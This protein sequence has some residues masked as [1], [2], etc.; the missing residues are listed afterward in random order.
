[1][2]IGY[3]C[4]KP[5][6]FH[7]CPQ[8]TQVITSNRQFINQCCGILPVYCMSM[9]Q[10]S[11]KCIWWT[12]VYVVCLTHGAWA[13][14]TLRK[15]RGLRSVEI[16]VVVLFCFTECGHLKSNRWWSTWRQR[17]EKIWN[18]N[19]PLKVFFMWN[20][21]GLMAIIKR[22]VELVVTSHWD[23]RP[24]LSALLLEPSL[25][26]TRALYCLARRPN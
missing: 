13:H 14:N 26:L 8:T 3:K 24:N 23:A 15:L 12:L 17:P 20:Q 11:A 2:Y 16:L 19:Q 25:L 4:I 18:L 21:T 7:C 22:G 1:M 10:V 6:V 9:S 5:A